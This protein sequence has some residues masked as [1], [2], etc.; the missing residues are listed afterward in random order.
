[1]QHLCPQC[2]CSSVVER[3]L[4]K[5]N[6]AGS[7]PV[8]RSNFC[9]E[10]TMRRIGLLFAV[11]AVFALSGCADLDKSLYGISNSV[12]AKDRVTGARS[13]NLS[14]RNSQIASSNG[15]TDAMLK[16]NYIDAGKPIN[17][18]VDAAAYARLQRVFARVHGVSH[19]ANEKWTA[20]LLPDNQWNA[21]TAGGSEIFV[22]KGLMDGVRSDD[23]LA[24]VIGHEIGHVAANHIYERQAFT[25]AS[26]LG[27]S[28]AA[29][30]QSF[31]AAFTIKDEQEADRLGVLYAALA[32]YDPYAASRLWKRMYDNS[33]DFSLA[34]IDHPI[35][36]QR[37]VTSQQYA[38]QYKQYYTNGRVNPDAAN[39][40]GQ[41]GAGIISEGAVKPGEGAGLLSVLETAA[42]VYGKKTAAKQEEKNQTQTRMLI[43]TVDNNIQITNRGLDATNTLFIKFTY[44]GKVQVS[45][46]NIAAQVG[47][48][49]VV[50]T[51]PQ[52][53]VMPNGTGIASFKFKN[54]QLSKVDINKIPVAV[55]HVEKY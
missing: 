48:E 4:P 2:G 7:T 42:D 18:Q 39:I 5:Q 26:K 17:A 47:N 49:T 32:G 20:Y 11:L 16:K 36:S 30:R 37:A 33:G 51:V 21:F 19:M 45:N 55:V 25:L 12:T 15:Q 8:S 31:Q 28:D 41:M 27:G 54:T 22:Y 38:D 3:L 46:L 29:G 6:V 35:N 10:I 9:V 40:L 34:V 50:Y 44:V 52:A 14:D 13:L 24:A 53:V 1:M 43:R 23:E